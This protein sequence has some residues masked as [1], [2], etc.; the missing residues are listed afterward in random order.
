MNIRKL[1][2]Y[3]IYLYIASLY[4]LAYSPELNLISKSI[5]TVMAALGLLTIISEKKC[6]KGPI[7]IYLLLYAFL[8]TVSC[9]WSLDFDFAQT[10]NTSIYLYFFMSMLIYN[11]AKGR[12]ELQGIVNGIFWGTMIMGLQ[13]VLYYGVDEI[14]YRMLHGVRMGGEINQENA[15]G[16][17]NVI[18]CVIALHKVIYYKKLWYFPFAI[19]AAV[20]A[21]SS[22]SRRSILV[23][24]IA[25]AMLLAFR[26]GTVSI[27]KILIALAAVAALFILLYSIEPIRPLFQRFT[28]FLDF[29]D[30]ETVDADSS[31]TVRSHMISF[32]LEKFRD[33]PLLGYGTENYNILYLNEFGVLR[34]SHNNY[35]QTVVSYGIVGL[36]FTYYIYIW[37]LKEAAKQIKK[38]DK[39]AVMIFVILIMELVSHIT[40]CAL[41][42]KFSYI[43]ITMG[44]IYCKI[45]REEN[46]QTKLPEPVLKGR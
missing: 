27:T 34:P 46:E 26:K 6:E 15:F 38:L 22:G 42:N 35:I 10:K 8:V 41:T 20:M 19:F 12:E 1:A 3:S 17:Y 5:F 9:F 11:I 4:T 14:M 45:V 13:S 16:Y 18:A 24:I 43:Y 39:Q 29:F 44:F 31:M 2:L 21:F 25:T 37:F 30:A 36:I 33:R 32:G 23:I 40:T 7:Y 28:S